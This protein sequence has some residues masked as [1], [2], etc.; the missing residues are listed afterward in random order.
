MAVQDNASKAYLA[1]VEKSFRRRHTKVARTTVVKRHSLPGVVI[2]K[3]DPAIHAEGLRFSET[4][5]SY[6]SR[7][8]AWTTGSSP[9]VT[10]MGRRLFIRDEVLT[11][12]PIL[13]TFMKSR[14][15]RAP[16]AR[17]LS[18]DGAG[19]GA[20]ARIYAIRSRAALGH[21]SAGKRTGPH[22]ACLTQGICGERAKHLLR[23]VLR[24]PGSGAEPS[25]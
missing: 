14:S 6:S 17:A 13:V 5:R 7:T 24:K 19:C 1:R 11:I 2:A 23:C 25:R 22:G 10:V 12:V 8:S 16:F 3:L 21:R 15:P 20:R 9:V 18:E 4:Y